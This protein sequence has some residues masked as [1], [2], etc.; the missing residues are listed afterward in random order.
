MIFALQFQ[1][2]TFKD[3]NLAECLTNLAETLKIVGPCRFHRAC[4]FQFQGP[5]TL[6]GARA[7]RGPYSHKCHRVLNFAIFFQ[8][9]ISRIFRVID[10][11]ALG[12]LE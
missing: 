1:I 3:P 7:P 10:K 9:Y 11:T 6:G 2:F 4:F 5:L 12:N 8:E